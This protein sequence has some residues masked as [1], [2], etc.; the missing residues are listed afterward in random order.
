[1]Q[2]RGGSH[3]TL[4][5]GVV[6]RGKMNPDDG[7]KTAVYSTALNLSLTAAK[8]IIALYSG[9]TAVLSEAVHSL[10]DV[11]GAL[12]VWAGI[13]LSKKK[14]PSFPWGLYKAENIAAGV[15]ALFIFI[16]AYEI[17]KGIFVERA[18][19]LSNINLSVGAL[20]LMAIPVYL[21]ARYEKKKARELNSPS[22]MADAK[23]WLSDLAPIGVAAAGLAVS[24]MFSHADKVAALVVI[25]FVLRSGYGIIKDSGKSLLDASVDAETLSKLRTIV[26]GFREVEEIIALN[27]RN[28]G[29]FIFV[30]L[31]LR[32][33]LKKFK[34]AYGVIA[35][36]EESVRRDIPFIE[37]VIIR[38][39]PIEKGYMRY[40]VPLSDRAGTVSEHFG[41]A[42]FVACWNRDTSNGKLLSQEIIENPFSSLE[43]GK[44]IKL[45]ELIVE[46]EA[47]VIY[48]K[49]LFDGKG[50][51][52]VLSDA[53]VEVRPTVV[54]TLRELMELRQEER[55]K[56]F[57]KDD[58]R[59]TTPKVRE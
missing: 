51:E 34:D 57:E 4:A 25:V 8:G 53:G 13:T 9:S 42:P 11:F 24:R 15:S 38:Y 3:E 14:S 48:T 39:G 55:H 35:R 33:S 1:M 23:H 18:R 49:E 2:S 6:N 21:F 46:Q 29:R 52:Y 17:A 5:P 16:M 50:P 20:L 28:S 19:N 7:G 40:S 41:S 12:S 10:T 22:L 30:H 47:D 36:I 37:R 56:D 54:K 44:G 43:K 32:L 45:A 59:K 58:S 31:D 27:A 26:G